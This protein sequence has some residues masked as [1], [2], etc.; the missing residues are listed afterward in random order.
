MQ[1]HHQEMVETE[2]GVR[3]LTSAVQSVVE[4]EYFSYK[5]C[6]LWLQLRTD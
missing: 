3:Q 4:R 2:E 6:I 1:L 5:L